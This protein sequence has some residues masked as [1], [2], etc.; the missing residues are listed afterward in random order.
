MSSVTGQPIKPGGQYPNVDTMAFQAIINDLGLDPVNTSR[1]TLSMEGVAVHRRDV[2]AEGAAG[3]RVYYTTAA[4]LK[5]LS[6]WP[7]KP[8]VVDFGQWQDEF[9]H[10]MV[11]KGVYKLPRPMAVEEGVGLVRQRGPVSRATHYVARQPQGELA[12]GWFVRPMVIENMSDPGRRVSPRRALLLPFGERYDGSAESLQRMLSVFMPRRE[13]N[14]A[15]IFGEAVC[16]RARLTTPA[17]V[18]QAIDEPADPVAKLKL[19]HAEFNRKLR[20]KMD[21]PAAKADAA[22][23]PMGTKPACDAITETTADYGMPPLGVLVEDADDAER[24]APGVIDPFRPAWCSGIPCITLPN[25]AR[26]M[27]KEHVDAAVKV[28]V[29]AVLRGLFDELGDCGI[30]IR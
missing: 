15:G 4:L 24:A 22:G 29:D 3:D 11:V 9:C 8:T 28:K 13:D 6:C 18:I 17:A 20:A 23:V 27:A 1:V 5:I 21:E 19:A 14:A 25:G 12:P 16:R 10:W 7:A 26:M 30:V 2:A